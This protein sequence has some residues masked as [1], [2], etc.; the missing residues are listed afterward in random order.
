M[1]S[2]SIWH[3]VV[4]PVIVNEIVMALNSGYYELVLQSKEY[5][6]LHG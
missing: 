6:M 4:Q 2:V 5:M 1:L 3:L